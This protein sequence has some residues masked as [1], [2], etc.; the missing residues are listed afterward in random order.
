M[1]AKAAISVVKAASNKKVWIIGGTALVVIAL[2]LV[3]YFTGKKAGNTAKP[4]PVKIPNNGADIPANWSAVP[5]V[6]ALEEE[7]DSTFYVDDEVVLKLI[8]P[9]TKG[10]LAAV[11]NEYANR[12]GKDLLEDIKKGLS[13]TDLQNALNLF[14]G[15]I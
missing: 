14:N 9:L 10:Q 15:I 8:Q 2:I 7:L 3:I 12:Y 11:Y 6:I 5:T 13:G 4:R 1:A